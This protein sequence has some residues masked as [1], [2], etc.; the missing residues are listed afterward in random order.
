M[1]EQIRILTAE[2]DDTLRLSV[3]DLVRRLEFADLLPSTELEGEWSATAR[4]VKP[5]I[6]MAVLDT[7]NDYG[8]TL[9][10]VED[11]KSELPHMAVFFCSANDSAE[12]V[13]SAMRA[14][15]QEFLNVPI[16][17]QDFE[18]AIRKAYRAHEQRHMNKVKLGAAIS[19]FSAKGG[20]G[21]SSLVVNLAIAM[22][23]LDQVES[24]ILDLDL[25]VGDIPGFMDITPQYDLLDARDANGNIDVAR[26]QSCMTRHDSGV[27]VM[28]G[29]MNAGRIN[30]ISASLVKQAIASLRTMSSYILIDTAHGF[31]SRTLAALESSNLIL[32]PVIPSVLSVRAARRSL[33]LLGGLGY[34]RTRIMV[35]I[36]RVSRR[37]TI[38]SADIEK[39]LDYPVFWKIPNDYKTVGSAVDTGRPFT[40]GKR[41][42]KVGKNFLE[43]A[44]R[45]D[46]YF[47]PDED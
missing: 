19:V 12:L 11:L 38:K 26:L 13:L 47:Y 15:G 27:S 17:A 3:Q 32:V 31:D 44:D 37:D 30:E 23:R 22:G 10:L 8:H 16:N 36:N 42:S 5:D 46:R 24:A 28:A 34:D 4:A 40:V 7:A 6:L 20:Q 39:A 18:R 35:I 14:G 21:S 25:F 1:S 43:L 2:F 41:L 29:L 33:D 45:I 9:S